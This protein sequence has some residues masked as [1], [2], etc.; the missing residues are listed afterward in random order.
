MET[1]EHS[2]LHDVVSAIAYAVAQ[3]QGTPPFNDITQFILAQQARMPDYLRSP[4]AGLTLGFDL[5]GVLRTGHAFHSRAP[6]AREKQLSAW[7]ESR[8]SVKRDFVRY[9]QSLA[10]LALHSRCEMPWEEGAPL[11]AGAMTPEPQMRCEIAVVGSGPGGAITACLLAEAGREVLMVEEGP[12]LSPDCCRPFS[13]EEMLLKYRNGGQTL[14]LGPN[15]IPYVEGRCVGGGSEINSGLYHRTSPEILEVWRKEFLVEGLSDAELAPHFE[16]CERELSV[17]P[18]P[19]PAPAASLKLLQGA[20]KLNWKCL[21]VPRWFRYEG[22]GDQAGTRQT[23][24]RTYIPRFLRAG[25]RLVAGTRVEKMRLDNGR[26]TLQAR[27]ASGGRVTI[28]AGTVFVAAGAVQT[29]AL[30]RRSGIREQVGNC[31]RM[32]P[33]AKIV[34][35]FPEEVNSETMGVPVHQVKEFAPRLTFGCSISSRPYLALG[36]LDFPEALSR[37]SDDWR[38]MATYYTMIAGEGHGNVRQL[39]AFKDA[40]VRYKLTPRDRRDLAMGIRHLAEALFQAGAEALYPGVPGVPVL[41]SH[42]DLRKVPSLIPPRMSSLMTI[43]L[44]SSCPMGEQWSRCA[45]DSYGRVHGFQN[46]HVAD[47][48]LLCTAPGVNPQGT[49]MAL[50]RRNALKFLS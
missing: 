29:P 30:L 7:R 33:T 40:V 12:F 2:W 24:T 34:A 36:L 41:R 23:M 5:L 32:H 44:F 27:S 39:P 17:A 43:H 46:L 50:A 10:T 6:A 42:E 4:M 8:L 16:A 18:L 3:E 35:R 48:S 45:T 26:W 22:P 19:G 49:I 15:K 25:G 28:T 31:L 47:A 20:T 37:V 21:E 13:K 14:T 9:Y 38:Q 1:V 11:P